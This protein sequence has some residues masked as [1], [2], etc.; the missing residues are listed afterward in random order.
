[1]LALST[2]KTRTKSSIWFASSKPLERSRRWLF[3]DLV[4]NKSLQFPRFRPPDRDGTY[5]PVLRVHVTILAAWTQM[6][7][8]CIGEDASRLGVAYKLRAYDAHKCIYSCRLDIGCPAKSER[9]DICWVSAK[10]QGRQR[11]E[12]SNSGRP[13]FILDHSKTT[14]TV[15]QPSTP[16]RPCCTTSPPSPS[17]LVL[18]PLLPKLNSHTLQQL[19]H[20]LHHNP[21]ILLL[22]QPTGFSLLHRC[23]GRKHLS[24][25]TTPT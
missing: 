4:S 14:V 21:V 7:E 2:T 12:N 6:L 17:N 23:P 8:V 18:L 11:R 16:A 19:R 9:H 22:L 20:T 24:S 5:A 25:P 10:G 1:M 3:F 13:V 15:L